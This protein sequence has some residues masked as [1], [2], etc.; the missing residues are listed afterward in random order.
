MTQRVPDCD[1]RFSKSL[2]ISSARTASNRP[3][4]TRRPSP[5]RRKTFRPGPEG[6]GRRNDVDDRPQRPDLEAG[7]FEPARK[8]VRDV[9]LAF[10]GPPGCD[11]FGHK[12][13]EVRRRRQE[14]PHGVIQVLMRDESAARPETGR[15]LG[16][17]RSGLP[18]ERQ[19]PPAPGAVDVRRQAV[20]IEV[21]QMRGELREAEALAFPI[22]DVE[23]PA[24]SLD[25]EDMAGVADDPGEIQSRIAGPGSDVDQS[26]ACRETCAPPGIDRSGLPDPVLDTEPCHFL[27]MRPE[28]VLHFVREV[29]HVV[30]LSGRVLPRSPKR[31][32]QFTPTTPLS[33]GVCPGSAAGCRLAN[34]PG[35]IFVL[36]GQDE[37]RTPHGLVETQPA[38][39]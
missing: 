23:K 28:N 33:P 37:P 30:T 7:L 8:V 31:D 25:G 22:E 17:D 26:L 16:D 3:S 6:V 14:P 27:V 32:V 4:V 24:R 1:L 20:Q 2:R 39:R 12:C 13:L 11:H 9:G 18:D 36:Y 35:P 15:N 38:D 29:G 34:S 21:G 19:H 5:A 10:I